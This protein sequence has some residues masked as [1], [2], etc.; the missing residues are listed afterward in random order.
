VWVAV[1]MAETCVARA[2]EMAHERAVLL[3]TAHRE[4]DE[5]PKRNFQA[6]LPMQL[7]P[8]DDG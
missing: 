7:L 2:K 3:A 6:W 8:L 5:A 1:V 4:P